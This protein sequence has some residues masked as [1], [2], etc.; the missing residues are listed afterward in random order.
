MT[1]S[2]SW[3]RWKP[4]RQSQ[5]YYTAEPLMWRVPLRKAADDYTLWAGDGLIKF[6]TTKTLPYPLKVNMAMILACP[7]HDRLSIVKDSL[8]E[9][10]SEGTIFY[11]STYPPEYNDVGWRISKSFYTIIILNDVLK[12]IRGEISDDTRSKD[13]GEGEESN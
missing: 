5:Q 4:L 1:N 2:W 11:T 9:T 6:Y 12:Q 8:L 10:H 7:Q 3:S 13:K